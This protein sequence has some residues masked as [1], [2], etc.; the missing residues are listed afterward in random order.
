MDPVTT[1]TRLWQ[2][3]R[4]W[5]RG[6]DWRTFLL[7]APALAVAAGVAVLAGVCLNSSTRELHARYLAEGKAAFQAKDYPRALT[8]YERVAPATDDPAVLYRLALTAEA[9]GDP[10]RAAMLMRQLAPD[11]RKGYPPAHYWRARR[12]LAAAPTSPR[13]IAAAEVHLVRALDGE[14]D[15]REAV[16]GLLGTI[17]LNSG[18]LEDAEF[19]LGKAAAGKP[20]FRLPLAR[21]FALRGNPTRARQEAELAARFYHDRAKADPADVTA[22]LAWAD[23]VT[24]LEDFPAAVGIL[25]EGL[26]A[27]NAPI[28]R[29]ALAKVYVAWYDARKKQPG[30]LVGEL[31]GLL[32]K[33]LTHDPANTDL[34]NRMLDQLRFGGPGADQ[35]RKTLHEILARGGTAVG[36]IHFALAVDA[37]LRGDA[38]A[39]RLHLEQAFRLDPKTGLVANNLAWVLSQPPNPDLPRALTLVNI[40]LER[41]PNNPAF[42]D[43]RGRIYLAM[44]RWQDAL[45]DL[46]VVLA[47]APDTPGL[48]AALAEVYEKLGQP[49]LAAEHRALAAEPPRKP[50]AP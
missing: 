39:E 21:V 22:R 32:D 33:G 35:T 24:F 42:L 40:A 34:L 3:V 18:R 12:I 19:H 38:D 4:W 25:E 6:R 13:A 14:L 37:R 45:T 46:E 23:A 11:D 7:G 43:T 1:R 10:G 16:H 44:G 30:V 17:Y 27:T 29:L 9:A 26:A 8:C 20:I 15:D 47:K 50:A 48:H 49:A 31:I 41:E 28:Y 36:P 2:R 5:R